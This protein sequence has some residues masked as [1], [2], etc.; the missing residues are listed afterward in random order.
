MTMTTIKVSPDTRD[1]LKAQAKAAHRSLG[2][3]LVDL[4]DLAERRARFDS[5]RQAITQTSAETRASHVAESAEW[6][7]TELADL[8]RRGA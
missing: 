6:E 5:L 3:F 1:R 8:S 2:E 7:R 4:A